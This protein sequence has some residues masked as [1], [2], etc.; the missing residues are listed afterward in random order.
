MH[1]SRSPRENRYRPSVDVLFRSA[2]QAFGPRVIGVILSGALD[3]GALGL[4]SIE[5]LGG[6]AMVQDPAEATFLITSRA[7]NSTDRLVNRRRGAGSESLTAR[8]HRGCGW[9]RE[10]LAR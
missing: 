8:L 4:Q 5:Q 7:A 6:I 3:D 2:A 9:V 10:T 1:L